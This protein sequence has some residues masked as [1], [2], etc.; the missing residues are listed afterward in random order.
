MGIGELIHR[1]LSQ[2][3]A[4]LRS[5]LLRRARRT[6]LD[7][8][9]LLGMAASLVGALVAIEHRSA[10]GVLASIG[11]VALL[12]FRRTRRGLR[13]A[14]DAHQVRGHREQGKAS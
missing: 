14:M 5:D 11:A 9:E 6:P 10:I 8:A 2:V 7:V 3:T 4:D 13:Q 12:A 1:S